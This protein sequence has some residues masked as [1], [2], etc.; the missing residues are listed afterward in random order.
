MAKKNV[1][2][3]CRVST[4]KEDQAN[5]LENQRSYFQRYIENNQEWNLV[6][7]YYDD[8]ISGTSTKK[9]DGFNR[10]IMDA[11]NGKIDLILTKEVS[12]F[13]RNTVD[14][15]SVT[16]QLK[17]V[18]VGVLFINDNINTLNPEDELRLTIMSSIAQEESRK[19]SERVKWGHMRQ[20]EK[21]VVFGHDMLGYR[22]R[23]GQLEVVPEE[24]EIVRL[25]FHKYLNEQKG[26]STIA[27]E[28]REAGITT[29]K[30]NLWSNTVL[31]RLLRNEKYVGDLCQKKTITTDYLTHKKQYNH[32]EEKMIYIREHHEPI[33][34]R[35]T[36]DATQ[37]EL[38][39]RKP[40]GMEHWEKHSNRYWCSGKLR[41]GECGLLM[42]SRKRKNRN[43]KGWMCTSKTRQGISRLDEDQQPVKC[44]NITINEKILKAAV[45]HVLLLFQADRLEVEDIIRKQILTIQTKTV[46]DE[47]SK[48]EKEIQ[49]IE[50]KQIKAVDLMLDGYIGKDVLIRRQEQYGLDLVALNEKIKRINEEDE[51]RKSQVQYMEQAL[52]ELE[53][54]L[55]YDV[56]SE[57]LYGEV[58]EK[59]EVY[60]DKRLK[61]K[62]KDIP[63]Q[64]QMN[65]KTSGKLETYK[66]EFTDV[67]IIE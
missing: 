21:G 2:A 66:I 18:G 58:L 22:V 11:E 47:K 9:R 57:A 30:G 56:D 55:R 60:K 25:I 27:K 51:N 8:G 20:M 59:I 41:C 32:G 63:V 12:R 45:R 42:V 31:L 5:S 35:E 24:A 10:M 37:R 23:N 1:A 52:T 54:I 29:I 46:T 36:W 16:R 26:T 3:Y 13:A 40:K 33:I 50:Q 14:T 64:V 7:V 15:L 28:L 44:D 49:K 39:R 6:D 43:W 53:S 19:T 4:D 61:I 38:E 34:D 17:S 48:I 65:F 62:L 67:E